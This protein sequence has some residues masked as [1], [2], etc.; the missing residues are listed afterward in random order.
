MKEKRATVLSERFREFFA[1]VV[2]C[3][4]VLVQGVEGCPR[5]VTALSWRLEEAWCVLEKASCLLI[6]ECRCKVDG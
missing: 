1:V 4:Q 5:E 3:E 2:T 6:L